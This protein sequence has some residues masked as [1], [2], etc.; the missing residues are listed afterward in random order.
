MIAATLGERPFEPG[1]GAA[2][3]AQA[4]A[5]GALESLSSGEAAAVELPAARVA[6]AMPAGG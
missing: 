2:Y 1:I 5:L 3:A 6:S 4:V